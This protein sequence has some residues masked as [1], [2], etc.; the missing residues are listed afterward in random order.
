MHPQIDAYLGALANEPAPSTVVVVVDE[1]AVY[2]PT[3]VASLVRALLEGEGLVR[4]RQAVAVGGSGL[5]LASNLS[6][7][8]DSPPDAECHRRMR[9]LQ[10]S[11]AVGASALPE[12]C[13]KT[14]DVL[15]ALG[16]IAFRRHAVHLPA[17]C[18]L[19]ESAPGPVR[20]GATDLLLSSHLGARGVLLRLVSTGQ[21]PHHPHSHEEALP[22]EGQLVCPVG[23][24]RVTMPA[25]AVV[26]T[27]L[28]LLWLHRQHRAWK[29]LDLR[30]LVRLAER[31]EGFGP[32]SA[33]DGTPK[34]GGSCPALLIP[35]VQ[36]QL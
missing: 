7:V 13:V 21:P 17:L 26:Y 10:P 8:V 36:V 31:C 1:R 18:S 6:R 20:H 29:R 16:A 19:V 14:V 22:R 34:A 32:L 33:Q 28:A 2:A 4:R 12:G 3:V 15:R 23:A 24:Q 35:H 9:N 30:S 25:L 11:E 5:T 27:Q